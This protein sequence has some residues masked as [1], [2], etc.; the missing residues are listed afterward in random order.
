MRFDIDIGSRGR[1]SFVLIGCAR[2]GTYKCTNKEFVRKDTGCSDLL[3]FV[4]INNVEG[5]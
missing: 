4:D 2:S 1:N 3:S 5:G